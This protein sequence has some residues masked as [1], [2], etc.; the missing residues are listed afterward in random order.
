VTMTDDEYWEQV[1]AARTAGSE[2]DEVAARLRSL[3]EQRPV[4]EIVA[5]YEAQQR[6]LARSYTTPLWGAAYLING[7]C[8]DDGFD[9]FRGWLMAHGRSVFERALTDPDSLAD[10]DVEMDEA[11]C[12]EMIGA[13]LL[14]HHARTGEYPSVPGYGYP[15][16]EE[17]PDFDDDDEMSRRYPRLFAKYG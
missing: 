2:P 1:E 5:F 14:A 15:Q 3:L 9:Y 11:F 4:E 13:A 10:V 7:G 17:G 6:Q 12:E 8:S 16:L